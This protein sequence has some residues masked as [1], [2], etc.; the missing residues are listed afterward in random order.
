MS[1]KKE[2]SKKNSAGV[3]SQNKVTNMKFVDFKQ[4]GLDAV[5]LGAKNATRKKRVKRIKKD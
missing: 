5:E 2:K 1:D 4:I 3:L